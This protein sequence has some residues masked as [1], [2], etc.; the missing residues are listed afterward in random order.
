MGAKVIISAPKLLPVRYRVFFK[1]N[2]STFCLILRY[3]LMMRMAC[4]CA[5]AASI[6]TY[7]AMVVL[8]HA[9]FFGTHPAYFFA[10]HQVLMGNFR[11]ALQ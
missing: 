10:K 9:A 2:T 4:F 6:G 11:F 1:G 5:L 3:W 8:V 7:L